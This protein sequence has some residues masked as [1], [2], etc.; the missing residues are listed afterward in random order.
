MPLFLVNFIPLKC[1]ICIWPHAYLFDANAGKEEKNIE[2]KLK[3]FSHQESNSSV[4]LVV[5]SCCSRDVK[6]NIVGVCFVAQDVTGQKLMMDKYTRIQGDYVAIVQNPNELIPPIFIVNEY[7]CC[8]E[9][10]SAMEKVSGI[11]RKDAIDK[12]LVG[13]LFCL[14]GFGCRVKDHDTLTKLRIVLNGVMAGE[15]AD[16]FIFGFFD[17]NGNYVEALLSANKRIDSEG[18]NTG[19]LCFMRVASPELQHALQVQKLSEQAAIN[20]LKELAYLRQE[21]RNSLNGITF[22]QNLMEATDLTE[23]QKQLLRRKALCQEQL[24]KI[25]D[26]MDLDSIEQ[27]YAFH[28]LF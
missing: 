6:D 8:F 17:L 26:D 20:S 11:K 19:A 22:T 2:I 12:M 1:C 24:A 5:N 15:D 27:W 25:L 4:I 10:N 23:E 16:K 18:K 3:S 9:W 21:I 13:E 14:H 7:G 28:F